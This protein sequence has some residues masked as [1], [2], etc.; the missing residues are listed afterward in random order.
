MEY[1]VSW[2]KHSEHDVTLDEVKA[3]ELTG[4]EQH[5]FRE[6]CGHGLHN[7]YS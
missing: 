1:S 4:R 3:A 7:A 5:S 6:P 2:R